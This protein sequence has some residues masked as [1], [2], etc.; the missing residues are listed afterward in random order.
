VAKEADVYLAAVH[1]HFG[2]KDELLG[3]LMRRLYDG[4]LDAGAADAMALPPGMPRVRF[5]LEG[6]LQYWKVETDLIFF[7]ILAHA[8][9]REHQLE[10]LRGFY[11]SWTGRLM[12]LLEQD[13]TLSQDELRGLAILLRMLTDGIGIDRI[14]QASSADRE[15]AVSLLEQLLRTWYESRPQPAVEP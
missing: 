14:V 8:A 5:I 1:Y 2:T 6:W 15:L 3:E 11:D 4:S 13:G 9:R 12:T 7:E 10:Y